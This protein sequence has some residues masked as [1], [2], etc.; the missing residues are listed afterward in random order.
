VVV[1]LL[2]MLGAVVLA[3]G[4]RDAHVP[5]LWAQ[6]QSDLFTLPALAG[7]LSPVADPDLSARFVLLFAFGQAV[8]YAA[9]LRLIPDDL[10]GR[11]APRS[12][13]ASYRALRSELGVALLLGA[14]TTWTAL[15]AW[16]WVDAE[17]AWRAY[18]RLATFHG[19]LEM[20]CMGLAFAQR[21]A[22]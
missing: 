13:A 15:L 20:A 14:L 18:L 12:F 4:V 8:H 21:R 3:S 10:R 5:G 9:W 19:P 6:G 2:A 16:T 7:M 22:P 11:R 17:A 1:P